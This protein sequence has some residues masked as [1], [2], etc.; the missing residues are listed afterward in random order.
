MHNRKIFFNH[1]GFKIV[2]R[3]RNHVNCFLA[4]ILCN[5]VDSQQRSGEN[6]GSVSR[7]L[8]LKMDIIDGKYLSI[9]SLFVFLTSRVS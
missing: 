7:T 5:L 6:T 4:M 1:M 3:A 9:L 2:T 8:N